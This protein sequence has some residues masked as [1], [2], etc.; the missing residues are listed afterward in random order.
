MLGGFNV[1]KAN[2]RGGGE[3][4][5]EEAFVYLVCFNADLI[6]KA[7]SRDNLLPHLACL[8]TSKK[9]FFTPL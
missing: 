7:F 8:L 5:V 4:E 6:G 3:G 1:T 2:E 9:D